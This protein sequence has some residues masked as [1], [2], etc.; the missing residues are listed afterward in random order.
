LRGGVPLASPAAAVKPV[1]RYQTSQSAVAP[2]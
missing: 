1:R 2:D